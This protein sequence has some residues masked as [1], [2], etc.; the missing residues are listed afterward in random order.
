[1]YFS[2]AHMIQYTQSLCINPFME[3]EFILCSL[4]TSCLL[5]FV[6]SNGQEEQNKECEL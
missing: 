2:Q 3:T 5:I 1:M 4:S 6:I